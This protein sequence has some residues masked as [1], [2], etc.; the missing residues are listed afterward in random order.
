M[1]GRFSQ[2]SDTISDIFNNK[3]SLYFLFLGHRTSDINVLEKSYEAEMT[4]KIQKYRFFLHPF[5]L[6]IMQILY[7]SP[8]LSSIEIKERLGLSWAYYH[9]SI[10][11]LVKLNL[12]RVFDDF[13]EEGS[14]RQ[15]VVLEEKGKQE[16]TSFIKLVGKY[17]DSA[18]DF[19]PDYDG[20]E[21]YP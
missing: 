20:D 16:Y 10:R 18:K 11:S 19:I 9:N 13:D 4:S 2:V 14:T 15:S 21:L 3:K 8:K 5:R 1:N 17:V 7:T 12:I 6:S